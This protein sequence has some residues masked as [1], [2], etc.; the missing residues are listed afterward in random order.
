M[1]VLNTNHGF[2]FG[3]DPNVLMQRGDWFVER[4]IKLGATFGKPGSFSS[5]AAFC[6]KGGFVAFQEF[7]SVD[8]LK[9]EVIRCSTLWWLYDWSI[10]R[11]T[12]CRLGIENQ[13]PDV[14]L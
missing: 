1:T 4:S 7:G 13:C 9:V 8:G 12:H 6:T 14:F 10:R 5:F 2:Q 3:N 11:S